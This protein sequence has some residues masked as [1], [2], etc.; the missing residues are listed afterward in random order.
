MRFD[1]SNLPRHTPRVSL[2]T[3]PQHDLKGTGRYFATM[4]I[5]RRRPLLSEVRPGGYTH[6]TPTGEC[7][8]AHLEE[9]TTRYPIAIDRM[10]LMPDHIHLCFRVTAALSISIL[11]ILSDC[12]CFA[13]KA[14]GFNA[15]TN[16]LWAPDYHIFV[17]FNRTAYARC[18]DYTANNPKRWWLTHD[19][20][21]L[22]TPTIATHPLLPIQYTWQFVGNLGLLE[23][24]LLFPII[25][26][27]ADTSEQIAHLTQQARF[28][29]QAGGTL[30]GGFISPKEKALLKDLYAEA[31]DLRL[32][33]LVPHTLNNYK[34]PA[35]ALN[36]FN[37]G[38][39]LLLTT[40]P[41]YPSDRPCLRDVC[42]RHNAIALQLSEASKGLKRF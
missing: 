19:T 27:R 14:A 42:L 35:S 41:D 8:K 31:P 1:C 39:R 22:L 40:T 16:R 20:T 21:Q 13:Q 2:I 6:W 32:I 9:L 37:Y 30:I 12:R 36:A 18:I 11:R 25:I 3:A 17:A 23:S 15:T 24:P 38:R 34:P 7:V 29:I 10:A 28:A 33:S 5:E 4:T 26:H